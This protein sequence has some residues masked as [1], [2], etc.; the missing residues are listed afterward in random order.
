MTLPQYKTHPQRV[1]FTLWRSVPLTL[2][3]PLEDN[4]SISRFS[5]GAFPIAFTPSN[6][7]ALW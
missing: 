2:G 4:H 3:L 1:C 5:Q 7:L 6:Y